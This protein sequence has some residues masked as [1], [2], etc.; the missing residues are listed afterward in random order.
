MIGRDIRTVATSADALQIVYF[1]KSRAEFPMRACRAILILL[2]LCGA[3]GYCT[4]ES[5]KEKAAADVAAPWLVL[6]DSGQYGESWFQAASVFRNTL[7]KEQWTNAMRSA[8]APLGNIVSRQLKSASYATKLP[9]A[10]AGEYVVL[11]FET[12]FA[13]APGMIETVTPMLD[14]DG[15][16]K[17]SGYFI[18]RAGG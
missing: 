12:S 7:S 13:N 3:V 10:P 11:Q 14:K 18:K 8:R 5:A 15:K 16:W 17:V 1:L 4:D 9:N 2:L 6:V